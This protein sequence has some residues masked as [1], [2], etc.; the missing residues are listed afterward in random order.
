MVRANLNYS[1]IHLRTEKMTIKKM[2]RIRFSFFAYRCLR[3]VLL[4]SKSFILH[5]YD[6]QF[7][8]YWKRFTLHISIHFWLQ[9]SSSLAANRCEHKCQPQVQSNGWK[10]VLDVLEDCLGKCNFLSAKGQ[11]WNQQYHTWLSTGFY[12]KKSDKHVMFFS[13][14]SSLSSQMLIFRGILNW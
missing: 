13:A 6:T 11:I 10:S 4:S 2:G 9:Q 7:S 8:R 5:I 3:I 1:Y 12:T 14:T